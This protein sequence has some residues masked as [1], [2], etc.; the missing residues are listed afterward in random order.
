MPMFKGSPNESSVW[1]PL[2]AV[3]VHMEQPW[4]EIS[5]CGKRNTR[6]RINTG[7]YRVSFLM[8]IEY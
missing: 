5:K 7:R 6:V 3:A 1:L 2:L 8:T 4:A